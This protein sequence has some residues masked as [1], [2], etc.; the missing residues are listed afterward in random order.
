MVDDTKPTVLVTGASS[1][2]GE[3]LARQAAKDKCDL[4]LV[5]RNADRLTSVAEMLASKYKVSVDTLALDVTATD[6][7]AQLDAVLEAQ[8]RHVAVLINN[9]G[10]G[11]IGPFTEADADRLNDMV[12]LNVASTAS[13]L[14]GP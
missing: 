13:F 1:G 11:D 14:P 9:A 6:A 12:G 10:L 5:A 3:E 2:I 7:L 4:L 8:G